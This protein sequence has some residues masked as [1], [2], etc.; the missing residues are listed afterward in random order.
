MTAP[1]L[2][3]GAQVRVIARPRLGRGRQLR[4]GTRGVVVDAGPHQLPA[5]GTASEAVETSTESGGRRRHV[6]IRLAAGTQHEI[7]GR[8]LELVA[9]D[10]PLEPRTDASRARW[11]LEQLAPTDDRL[12]ASYVPR[13]LPAVAVVLPPF[14]AGRDALRWAQLARADDVG[15]LAALAA[16]ALATATTPGHEPAGSL[17]SSLED[18]TWP[19]PGELDPASAAAL[20]TQLAPSTATPH[21][22][23]VAVWDGWPDVP[24][25]RFPGAGSVT[26]AGRRHL[27]LTGPLDGIRT[28]VSVAPTS[29]RRDG[30]RPASGI[31]WPEDHAWLV[32][33]PV[34]LP[35]TYVAGDDALI[36]RLLADP[37]LEG[38]RT[39]HDATADG[40][41][42]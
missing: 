41:S 14:R 1:V 23:D 17:V 13:S 12:V 10:H 25:E 15:G 34:D 21:D 26:V 35:W 28:P 2:W 7:P 39:S 5:F 27:L 29:S 3:R 30:G 40:L 37:E 11:F 18:L 42:A 31:W 9:G 19:L 20:L 32:S 38:R 4:V 16:M 36:E 8:Y 33:S 6:L 24:A 22:V